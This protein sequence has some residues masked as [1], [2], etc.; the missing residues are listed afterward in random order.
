ML[1]RCSCLANKVGEKNWLFGFLNRITLADKAQP[2]I[3]LVTVSCFLPTTA[4]WSIYWDFGTISGESLCDV[5]ALVYGLIL[6]PGNLSQRYQ[7]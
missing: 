3:Y 5:V 1:P 2:L 7:L 4:F 6:G